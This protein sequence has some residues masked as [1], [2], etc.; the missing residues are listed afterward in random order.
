MRGARSAKWVAGAI[1]VALAASACGGDDGDDG[2]DGASEGSGEGIVRIDGGEPQNALIPT[3]TNEQFGALVIQNVFSKLVDFADDGSTF[4]VAAESV[5][6]NEDNSLW[7]I[8]LKDGWTFHDGT[9]V[10]A[11]SYVNAWNWAAN[12]QNEQNNA[13]WFADIV[14]YE[15]VHP[16]EEGAEPTAETMSGLAVVDD[17]TF[18]IELTTPV[19]YYDYKLGYDAF[20]P[21]PESFYDDP[22]AFGES[23]VGN[24]PY[25]FVSWEHEE[26]I[27]LA[28]YEDYQ[29]D[30]AAQNGGI[31][32]QAYDSLE[33]AYTDLQS[34]N[35]DIIRQV[36]PRDLPL[37][38]QDLGEDRSVAQPYN[39][40]QTI[41]PVW[42]EW[43]ATDNPAQVLQGVSMA[44]DRET[45]T[46][47]V[48][49]GSRFPAD[50]YLPP[51]VY[52][53]QENADGTITDFN[54]EEAQRLV[55]EGGGVP[56]DRLVIQY[57]A[58]A[59]HQEWVEAVCN[60]VI[61][62]L[63]IE[64]VGDPLVDFA[65][66]LEA[67]EAGEVQSMYRG[68][69]FADYPL[70]VNFLKELYASYAHS[71]YG[72]FDSPE[73]D[74]LFAEGDAAADL[75]ATVAAYQEAE[76]LLFEQMPSIPLWFNAVNGG[77]G[78]NVDNVVFNSAGQPILT[79]VTVSE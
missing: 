42:Y 55:E 71:N 79:D 17:L 7:T 43:D 61:E 23:P 58:D 74:A 66:D 4:T 11:E 40:I 44:I 50:S 33:T 22:E 14:G 37:Y 48:L 41:T 64:C 25:E 16:E 35:L 78:P 45:I 69:W 3:N 32:I 73:V 76:Q 65:T 10:T 49:N 21:L 51:G 67:R 20:T 28:R 38:R 12:I 52:G 54:P 47:T 34:G 39:G 8:T 72:Q 77:W 59:D 18:T 31:Q 56:D 53:Y 19:S 15:D 30:N 1:A 5:E 36:A 70:N 24:G 57:N 46:Q 2:E 13:F 29:G 62:V 75:D 6:A 63:D 60:S 68:G 9:P 26:T 27:E